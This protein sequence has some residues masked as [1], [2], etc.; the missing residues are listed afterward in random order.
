MGKRCCSASYIPNYG[1]IYCHILLTNATVNIY[2][3]ILELTNKSKKNN[4]TG[5]IWQYIITDNNTTSKLW[6]TLCMV[7]ML[8]LIF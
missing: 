3:S 1:D 7:K 6:F 5:N 4:T 8:Q 2:D